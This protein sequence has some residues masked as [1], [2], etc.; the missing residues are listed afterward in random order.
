MRVARE[1]RNPMLNRRSRNPHVIL[2]N[3]AAPRPELGFDSA[4]LTRGFPVDLNHCHNIQKLV[5]SDHVL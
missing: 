1:Q 2:W 3:D 5:D 4:V